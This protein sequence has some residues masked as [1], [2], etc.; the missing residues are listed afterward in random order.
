MLLVTWCLACFKFN[1]WILKR[2]HIKQLT[3][4]H[5]MTII[6]SQVEV[7]C[8]FIHNRPDYWDWN[9]EGAGSRVEWTHSH[10]LGH[11]RLFL[12]KHTLPRPAPLNH[13]LFIRGACPLCFSTQT[14]RVPCEDLSE[15]PIG[16]NIVQVCVS[17]LSCR[18]QDWWPSQKGIKMEISKVVES[19]FFL[20]SS[21]TKSQ[22]L[23]LNWW[24]LAELLPT[25]LIKQREKGH[26]G[27][28]TLLV[29]NMCTPHTLAPC[30][31]PG[32]AP[33]Q[34]GTMCHQLRVM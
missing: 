7:S 28:K 34:V 23:M 5:S 12:T 22:G 13:S 16:E 17:V 26:Q 6:S 32:C 4:I 8:E 1:K 24:H 27:G 20:S 2:Q 30:D 15:R 33:P 11:T 3:M 29:T 21:R 9:T 14:E 10:S 19:V 18:T 25:W 31:A